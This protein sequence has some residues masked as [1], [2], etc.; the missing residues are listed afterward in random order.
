VKLGGWSLLRSEQGE[1]PT[2]QPEFEEENMRILSLSGRPGHS[3]I[4][5]RALILVTLLQGGTLLHG[6]SLG[7]TVNGTATGFFGGVDVSGWFSSDFNN[8]SITVSGA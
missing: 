8:S 2:R 6:A 4:V 1:L 5:T 7:Y 3:P